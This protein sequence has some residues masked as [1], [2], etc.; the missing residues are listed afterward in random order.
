M[1]QVCYLLLCV[2][3]S[4]QLP[5]LF[6]SCTQDAYEK[7]DG[8]TSAMVAEMGIGFTA[9]DTRVTSFVTD[10]GILFSVSNPFFSSLMPKADTTYRAVFYYIKDGEKAVVKGLNQVVVVSPRQMKDIKTDPVRF[11]SAWVGKS[12]Q[13]LNL[14][15]YLMQGYTDDEEAVHKIGFRRDSLYQNNDGTRTLHLTLYHDQAGVP[16]YYSQRVYVSAPLHSYDVDSIWLDVNTYNGWVEKR[17]K[18]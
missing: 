1:R 2:I 11:E 8:K 12:K 5:L 15:L 4:C 3:L 18:L 7:G 13:Y 9:S 14:S 16:E 10:D 6:T 17:I